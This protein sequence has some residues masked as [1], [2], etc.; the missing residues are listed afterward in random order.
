MTAKSFFFPCQGL[1]E[2]TCMG[3]TSCKPS[4]LHEQDSV[5][6]TEDKNFLFL[7]RRI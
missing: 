6:C 1:G 3:V 7:D 4:R 5:L 2:A